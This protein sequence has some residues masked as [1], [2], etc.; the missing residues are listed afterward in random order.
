MLLVG[1]LNH[2]L[3]NILNEA[4]RRNYGRDAFSCKSA[5]WEHQCVILMFPRYHVSNIMANHDVLDAIFKLS[6]LAS[7]LSILF[8][9]SFIVLFNRKYFKMLFFYIGLSKL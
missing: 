3:Q 4:P 1:W 8:S 5:T 6:V 2:C 7:R 9:V